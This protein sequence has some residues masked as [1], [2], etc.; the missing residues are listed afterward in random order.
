MSTRSEAPSISPTTF[1]H[2]KNDNG[3]VDSIC[4]NCFATI[5]TELSEIAL[6]ECEARHK[7][8]EFAR[9]EER[10]RREGFIN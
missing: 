3:T 9:E 6:G 5:G 1:A 8:D 7:C 4:R 2:R 10:K